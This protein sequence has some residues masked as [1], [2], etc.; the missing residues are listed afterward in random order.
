LARIAL[1]GPSSTSGRGSARGYCLDDGGLGA[2]IA[3]ATRPVVD[4]ELLSE[5]LRQPLS[6]QARVMSDDPPGANGAIRRTGRAG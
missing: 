6:D 4:N 2:D 3:A 5:P 1:P